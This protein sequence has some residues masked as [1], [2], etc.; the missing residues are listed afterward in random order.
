MN[1][2]QADVAVRSQWHSGDALRAIR[3]IVIINNCILP[4]AFLCLSDILQCV[5]VHNCTDKH[6]YA[7]CGLHVCERM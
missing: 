1:S 7:V 4:A 2:M 5:C 6:L 3:R